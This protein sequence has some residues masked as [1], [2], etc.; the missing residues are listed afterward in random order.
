MIVR[1]AKVVWLCVA[2]LIL[3]VTLYGFDGKPDSDI[4]VVLAWTMLF[5]SFPAGLIVSLIHVALYEIF[6]VWFSTSYLSLV[7]DWSGMFVLGYL[8]WFKSLPYLIKKW[9]GRRS[10]TLPA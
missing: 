7:L 4:G 8:Q 9:K 10:R 1:I 2:I 6:S 5:L 3:F